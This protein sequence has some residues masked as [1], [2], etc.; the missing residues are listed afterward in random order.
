[1]QLQN[2]NAE[3]LILLVAQLRALLS[4]PAFRLLNRA[5]QQWQMAN[6]LGLGGTGTPQ[7]ACIAPS[8]RHLASVT[9]PQSF[10]RARLKFI[11]A[12]FKFVALHGGG[13]VVRRNRPVEPP[14]QRHSRPRGYNPAAAP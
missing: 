10:L 8:P 4:A 12:R 2:R 7:T 13:P 5:L 6:G 11:R 9:V 14:A 3:M 1:M